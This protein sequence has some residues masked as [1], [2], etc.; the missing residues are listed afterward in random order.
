MEK[1][2]ILLL[3]GVIAAQAQK[4]FF[5]SVAASDRSVLSDDD[6]ATEVLDNPLGVVGAAG[7]EVP[8]RLQALVRRQPS[9]ALETKRRVAL[10]A[11]AMMLVAFIWVAV[12]PG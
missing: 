4:R 8:R 2:L 11:I 1:Y 12:T 9:R 6:L 5:D 3:F 7:R 10:A